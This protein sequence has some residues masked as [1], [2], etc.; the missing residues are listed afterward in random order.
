MTGRTRGTRVTTD[1][2]VRGRDGKLYTAQPLTPQ[3]R[4]RA[5]WLAH[6]LVHRGRLSIRQ[7]QRVMAD[8]HGIRRSIGAIA[9]DLVGF[10]CPDCAEG[11]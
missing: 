6:Q 7:A 11:T 10:E 9:A 8:S 4:A 2:R 3:E 1:V 5:R